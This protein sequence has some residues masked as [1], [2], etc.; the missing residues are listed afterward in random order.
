MKTKGK[1][2]SHFQINK[3]HY[4]IASKSTIQK[5]LKF[6][7]SED[8]EPP[9]L[10]MDTAKIKRKVRAIGKRIKNSRVF[11]AVKANPDIEI[12]KLVNSLGIGFEIASEGELSI[13]SGIGAAKERI[14]SSNPV[15]SYRFLSLARDYG[16][17][18]FTVDS[19]DE[20]DKLVE[21]VRQCNIYV[22]LSVPNEGSEWPLSKKFAVEL[23][24]AEELLIYARRKG[25]KPQGITFHVGSQCTN[26]Y[27]WNTALD[28]AKTLWTRAG[29]RGIKLSILNIGGGYP[30]RYTKNV[31]DIGTIESHI[32]TL[33]YDRFPKNTR[34]FIE[35]GRAI[36]GDAGVFV[37]RVIGKAKR[38][39]ERWLYLDVG[40]FNGLMESLGGIKYSYIV[41]SS[42]PPI[43]WTIA[44][45]SCDSFDVMDKDVM[46]PEPE[47]GTLILILSCGA[48]TVSYA[49]EFNGFSIP[50]TILI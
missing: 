6:I 13:L 18:H 10:L 34:V 28:K 16:I 24:E 12:L 48:Y 42:K 35:P 47:V 43:K 4:E 36:V 15:K 46:L 3:M 45:P 31:V 1:S 40:V 19:K 20:I 41:E 17:S 37:S 8:N 26:I 50:K 5:V 44:G 11:Y 38:A 49:S 25:L 2:T 29:K 23:D 27:S 9:Y 32:D 22:R 39:D 7:S 14:I 33:I 30:I 21:Y